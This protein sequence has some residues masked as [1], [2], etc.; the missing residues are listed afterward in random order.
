MFFRRKKR[1]RK[2]LQSSFGHLKT[3]GFNFDLI[4]CY[5]DRSSTEDSFQTLSDQTCNDLDFELFFCFI[6][7]TTSKIG[8]QYLY[9]QLRTI[10]PTIKFDHQERVIKYLQENPEDRLNIQY[11][12]NKLSH[13]Q[14]YYLSD[15]FQKKIQT[16]PKWYFIFPLLSFTALLSIILSFI[17]PTMILFFLGLLPVHVFI[18]YG[19][20][21]KTIIFLN[22]VPTLLVT[23]AVAKKLL[24]YSILKEA[25]SNIEKSIQVIS[26]IR[27]KMSFFKLEQKVDSDMEAAYWFLLELIKITFLLEPLLLFSSLDK[28]RNKSD[29]IEEVFRFI[30]KVDSYISVTSLRSNLE[31]YCTPNITDEVNHLE[32]K[33]VMHP[34]VADCVT[35]SIHTKHSVL[36]T[37]SNMSGK[38]TFIR[39][40]G[41]NY[42][43]GMTMN[44]CFAT[45][46]RLPI[47]KLYS[48]IRIEDD[49]MESKS[50]FYKEVDEIKKIINAIGGQFN[51]IVLLDELFK[52]TNTIERIA[53][54]KSVLSYIVKKKSQVFVSTHD[55]ELT[56]MLN[57]QFELFH[58]TESVINSSIHF[59]YK[60]KL[61]TLKQGNAIRILEIKEYP[62]EITESAN[63]IV[64]E[65]KLD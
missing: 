8:Q 5:H 50:Y 11:E 23:G 47:A 16:K 6:D 49:L 1:I 53:S 34:L 13:K 54:A 24:T 42:I 56:T 15:L 25:S 64:S 55:I 62:K 59:D 20:K 27:R 57:N 10:D 58:F 14:A 37:G 17:N 40:I 19:L 36:L 51:S 29:D 21:R 9:H 12:L 39:A 32:F 46:A 30:G 33:D 2:Q 28:L 61:G 3:E 44:T 31:N 65:M 63:A 26:S 4:Q 60:L 45:E 18:H 41:L 22:S 48:L 7:R 38:T 43:S 35:N 52:G